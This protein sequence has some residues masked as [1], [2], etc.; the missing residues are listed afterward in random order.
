MR[1]PVETMVMIGLLLEAGGDVGL[2][3]DA[4]QD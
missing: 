1:G 2:G 4:V 3:I